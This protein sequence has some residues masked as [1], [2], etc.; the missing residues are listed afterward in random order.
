MAAKTDSHTFHPFAGYRLSSRCD[1]DVRHDAFLVNAETSTERG[2]IVPV[3]SPSF[4]TSSS[5][6]GSD[7]WE[8]GSFDAVAADRTTTTVQYDCRNLFE[9][10]SRRIESPKRLSDPRSDPP[11][12]TPQV[13][14]EPKF[15]PVSPALNRH[16]EPFAPNGARNRTRAARPVRN[17]VGNRTFRARFPAPQSN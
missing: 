3:H 10:R 9:T 4:T 6:D 12:A 1:A 14:G 2:V 13:K 8:E 7:R 11:K 17:G 15:M 16:T 5:F